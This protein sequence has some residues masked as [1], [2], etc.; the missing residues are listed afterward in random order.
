MEAEKEA[1]L[2]AVLDEPI[3]L[4]AELESGGVAF[5]ADLYTVSKKLQLKQ[6]TDKN[7]GDDSEE[8]P[9]IANVIPEFSPPPPLEARRD[10]PGSDGRFGVGFTSELIV[11]PDLPALINKQ[12]RRRRMLR[13]RA[14]EDST[15]HSSLDEALDEYD[16][17][18]ERKKN[19]EDKHEVV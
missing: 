8:K 7:E 2:A 14:L 13:T 17:Q 6:G 12:E 15:T 4:D 16:K 10:D 1:E 9:A 5:L 18:R 11:P 19:G 3:S